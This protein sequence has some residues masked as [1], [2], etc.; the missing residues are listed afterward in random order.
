M[1]REHSN[2]EASFWYWGPHRFFFFME[3]EQRTEQS[4]CAHSAE[5]SSNEWNGLGPQRSAVIVKHHFAVQYANTPLTHCIATISISFV[6]G[7][8]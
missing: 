3:S 2:L 6:G 5:S 8:K 1:M 7:M 4:K